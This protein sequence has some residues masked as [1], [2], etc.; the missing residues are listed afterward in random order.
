MWRNVLLV[1][2]LTTQKSKKWVS[3]S[4]THFSK[5]LKGVYD[6]MNWHCRPLLLRDACIQ[7]PYVYEV[8]GPLQML[9]SILYSSVLLKLPSNHFSLL[10]LYFNYCYHELSFYC[11]FYLE[12]F[13]H[14]NNHKWPNLQKTQRI[15][16]LNKILAMYY[17]HLKLL[18]YINILIGKICYTIQN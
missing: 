7:S 9:W 10:K 4:L 14:M 3:V 11:L 5:K 1:V 15:G 8:T 16:P 18:V 2:I 12:L 17:K 6:V 13:K